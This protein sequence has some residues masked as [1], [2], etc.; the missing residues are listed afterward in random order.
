MCKGEKDKIFA[1]RT[2]QLSD[3][4][5]VEL[6]ADVCAAWEVTCPGGHS[7]LVARDDGG[8]H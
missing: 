1:R 2:L 4:H 5:H 6:L 7:H 3:K 8:Q